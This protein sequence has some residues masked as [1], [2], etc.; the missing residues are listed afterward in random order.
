MEP[1][2]ARCLF[3]VEERRL[4]RRVGLLLQAERPDPNGQG[5]VQLHQEFYEMQ[6]PGSGFLI[7]VVV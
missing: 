4:A 2:E 1:H 7:L 5:G 3:Y 6:S